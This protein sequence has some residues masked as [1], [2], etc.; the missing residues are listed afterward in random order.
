MENTFDND[1]ECRMMNELCVAAAEFDYFLNHVTGSSKVNPFL[2]GL[3]RMIDVEEKLCQ[4]QVSN[5]FNVQLINELKQI[6]DLK[7][8][9]R[10]IDLSFI[11]KKITVIR[12]HSSIQKQLQVIK[13]T[14][15]KTKE[16]YE[17]S[18]H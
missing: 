12:G 8:N 6:Q 17:V 5:H 16:S 15:E 2:T 7:S 10:H 18:Q 4:S 1:Q 13:Q 11:N 3:T 9:G 14:Q